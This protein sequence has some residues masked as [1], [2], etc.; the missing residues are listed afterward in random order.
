MA[1]EDLHFVPRHDEDGKKFRFHNYDQVV[2]CRDPGRGERDLVTFWRFLRS[3]TTTK[4]LS[5]RVNALEHIAVLSKVRRIELLPTFRH[6]ERL[7]LRGL[8]RPKGM[9]AAVAIANLLCCCPSLGDLQINLTLESHDPDYRYGEYRFLE[10]KF[11]SDRD[12]SIHLV[13][14]RRNSPNA[15]YD[16]TR[17]GEASEIPA[18][19]RRSFDCLQSSMKRLGLQFRLEDAN[20]FGVKLIKFFAENAMVLEEMYIDGGNDKLGDHVTRKLERWICN[21]SIK[22]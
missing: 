15:C 7:Q 17:C 22:R 8:H 18:L 12:K 21:S 4:E 2:P 13:N 5:L 6:L 3:F 20:C 9:T 10:R 19:S 1:R 14:C 11:R 16:D